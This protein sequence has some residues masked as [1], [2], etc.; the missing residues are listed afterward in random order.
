MRKKLFE[1]GR[2]AGWERF[3]D[4]IAEPF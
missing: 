3:I 2:I 1:L 4:I